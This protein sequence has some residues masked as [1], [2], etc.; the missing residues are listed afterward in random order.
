MRTQMSKLLPTLALAA[1]IA[2][3]ALAQ[4]ARTQNGFASDIQT[5]PVMGNTP[6][7]GG[8]R[9]QT[10]VSLLNPSATAISIEATLYD[11]NGMPHQATIALAAGEQKTYQ[12]FLD[13]VFH[14]TRGGAVTFRAPGQRFLVDAEVWTTGSRYGTSIPAIEIAPTGAPSYSTGISVDSASR[15]NIGCS[16]QSDAANAVRAT[17][18]DASGTMALGTVNLM[19]APRAWSQ[20]PVSAV[21]NNGYVRFEPAGAAVCYAVVVNNGTNDGRFVAATEYTP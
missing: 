8:S 17:I 9:F 6:G 3:P 18:Y 12:N 4:R 10:F 5:V 13:E 21:V 16:N 7:A 14:Y 20:A 15:T 19:L 2:L 11:P 1:V